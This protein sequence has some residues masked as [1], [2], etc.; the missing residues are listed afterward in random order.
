MHHSEKKKQTS[1]NAKRRGARKG[2]TGQFVHPAAPVYPAAPVR[3]NDEDKREED[4]KGKGTKAI[5][6]S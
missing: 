4:D 2:T 5:G 6:Q 3:G 1:G